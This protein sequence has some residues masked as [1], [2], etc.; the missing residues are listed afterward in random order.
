VGVRNPLTDI[1]GIG[2]SGPSVTRD[3]KSNLSKPVAHGKVA[4][5]LFLVPESVSMQAVVEIV[6]LPIAQKA[7]ANMA[8]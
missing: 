8:M 3:Q 2:W 1:A 6:T 7:G 4:I 5:L